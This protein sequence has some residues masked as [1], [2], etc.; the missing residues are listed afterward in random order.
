[1][2]LVS[3][4]CEDQILV[5]ILFSPILPFDGWLLHC[6]ANW[7]KGNEFAPL[8]HWHQARGFVHSFAADQKAKRSEGEQWSAQQVVW[9]RALEKVIIQCGKHCS[10]LN[11]VQQKRSGKFTSIYLTNLPRLL[12]TQN[13]SQ[14]WIRDLNEDFFIRQ[15]E[16]M[17]LNK[18]VVNSRIKKRQE[19]KGV[20]ITV[21]FGKTSE[22]W[23]L[24]N[25]TRQC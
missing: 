14:K 3:V 18:N 10:C 21:S 25:T 2:K 19:T 12:Q 1:M 5:C 6:F 7:E 20:N 11:E 15:R 17:H 16:T 8:G 9:A 23:K 4:Q 22:G 24:Y 13:T